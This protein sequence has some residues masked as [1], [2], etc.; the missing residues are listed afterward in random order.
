MMRNVYARS[1]LIAAA[2]AAAAAGLASPAAASPG[3]GNHSPSY[4]NGYDSEHSYYSIPQNHTFL[5][6]EM[7]KG[8]DTVSV[9]QLEIAGGAPPPDPADWMRGCIDALHDLG[10]KP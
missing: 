3:P 6:N 9:C 10:F 4:Q 8:Y 7:R 1:T 2:V 5:A